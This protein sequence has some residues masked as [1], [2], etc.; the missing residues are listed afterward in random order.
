[1]SSGVKGFT[2]LHAGSARQA[3][4]RLRFVAQLADVG[5]ALPMTAL[6]ALISEAVD[7]VVQTARTPAGLR[8]TEVLAVEDL[9]AG[10]DATTF[11]VTELFGRPR[12]GDP[13]C[14]TGAVP[15]RAGRALERAG[16][17]VRALLAAAPA[18]PDR[19]TVVGGDP[20]SALD[21][22]GGW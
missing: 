2:T 6:N 16:F 20:L 12:P 13:L 4:T 11:T 19:P 5:A 10:A 14:W 18:W 7:V 22:F 21:R 8:V 9:V 15:V 3:L 1:L 17:D